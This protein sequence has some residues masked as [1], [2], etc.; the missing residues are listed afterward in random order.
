MANEQRDAGKEQF[1]REA[2]ARQASSGLAVR[3][4]CRQEQ[5]AESAF[6]A[7]RRTI[8]ERDGAAQPV[9]LTPK[10]VPAV[11]APDAEREAFT[12]TLT[13]GYVLRMPEISVE[14][15]AELL[16]ALAARGAR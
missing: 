14:R 9:S 1:W 6:Y 2:V 11:I 10:F 7:W 8:S 5:L 3:S 13:G 16:L 15:L 12:L 4:F